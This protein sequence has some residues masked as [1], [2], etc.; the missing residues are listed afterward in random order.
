AAA[1]PFAGPGETVEAKMIAR[2]KGFFKME[3]EKVVTPSPH[4]VVPRCK[5]AGRC[6]GCAWQQFDYAY[7][8]ELKRGLV[9]D[10]LEAAGI[11]RRI[12]AVSPAVEIFN[13]RN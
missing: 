12:E 13:Y 4:R 10:A 7:Q 8:L 3:L 5:Y 2:N 6:G 9:N 1:V 11:G